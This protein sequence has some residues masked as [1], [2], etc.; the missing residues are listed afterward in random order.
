MKLTWN[1]KSTIFKKFYWVLVD[2]VS[3]EVSNWTD[4]LEF[5]FFPLLNESSEVMSPLINIEDMAGETI[6]VK[7]L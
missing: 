7:L 3:G 2:Q 5:E 1:I 4:T 6:S